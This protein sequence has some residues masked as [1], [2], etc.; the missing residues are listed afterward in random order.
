[1]DIAQ[2]SRNLAMSKNLTS[3]GTAVLSKSMDEQKIEGAGILKMMDAASMENSVNPHIG[4]NF[5][6]SV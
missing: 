2:I 6:V 5:D 1:M 3:V 4:G